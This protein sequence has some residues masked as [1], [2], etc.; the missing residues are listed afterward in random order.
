MPGMQLK[1]P[2]GQYV[3]IDLLAEDKF[4]DAMEPQLKIIPAAVRLEAPEIHLSASLSARASVEVGFPTQ[5]TLM[6]LGVKLDFIKLTTTFKGMKD[7]DYDCKVKGDKG[8]DASTYSAQSN[9]LTLRGGV[10]LT[11]WFGAFGFRLDTSLLPDV[12]KNIYKDFPIL[13]RCWPCT[14]NGC[15]E[16]L[17]N[18]LSI[19]GKER[20]V[21]VIPA[22]AI[23]DKL[24]KDFTPVA[25]ISEKKAQQK[26]GSAK[27]SI[28][29]LKK[30]H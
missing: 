5:P 8:Y 25:K 14:D 29:D 10:G 13:A 15:F 4:T 24:T 22:N 11:A 7:A 28:D 3:Q 26:A 20:K 19:K 9:A 2:K 21:L 18:K 23:D 1:I 6:D 12:K 17:V 30:G 16:N 27:G